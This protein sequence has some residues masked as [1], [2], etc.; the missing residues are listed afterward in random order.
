MGCCQI[1][2]KS[3][4]CIQCDNKNC[5]RWYHKKC[6]ENDY[7]YK[8]DALNNLFRDSSQNFSCPYC[9]GNWR[10]LPLVYIEN[11]SFDT[12]IIPILNEFDYQM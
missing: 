8:K 1:Q 7:H 4:P 12:A 2:K 3:V 11:Q 6:L 10:L 5:V 9:V